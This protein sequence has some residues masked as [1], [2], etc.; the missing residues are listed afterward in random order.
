M[1]KFRLYIDES[2]THGYSDSL[3][4]DKKYLG[5]LG[6]II[7]ESEYINIL[8]PKIRKLKEMFADDPDELPIL[9]RKDIINARGCFAKLKNED[10]KAAFNTTLLDIIEN[11]QYTICCV[12]L[13]KGSHLE[14]YGAAAQHPYHYCLNVLL[15]RYVFFLEEANSKGDVMI[16]A[17]GKEE[18]Q[19]LEKIYY[20][21]YSQGTSFK[22]TESIQ[23]RITSSSIKIRAKS[24]RVEGIEFA[25][26]LALAGKL[27]TLHAHGIISCLSDNFCKIIIEKIQPKFRRDLTLKRVNGFGKKLIK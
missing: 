18:D 22:S 24:S 16:E 7:S 25:D 19:K 17:R 6:V 14:R 9:H 3:D 11:T 1:E 23:R 26:L 5:L 21:F 2:G 13:D 4:I 20:S 10:F 15:E 27:D 12:V 8:Q